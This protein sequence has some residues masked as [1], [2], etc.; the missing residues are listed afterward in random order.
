MTSVASDRSEPESTEK[1]NASGRKKN[2]N[3][4]VNQKLE[5][6][7]VLRFMLLTPYSDKSKKK[8]SIS[9]KAQ[10]ASA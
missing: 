3:K 4:M 9:R 10:N 8:N 7:N 1:L 6:I 2:K 5:K